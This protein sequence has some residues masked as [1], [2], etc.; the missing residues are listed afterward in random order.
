MKR[1]SL[2]IVAVLGLVAAAVW[3]PAAA[4]TA[5]GKSS[6]QAP[7]IIGAAVDLTSSMKPFD[8]PALAGAQIE[9]GKLAAK[10][11]ANFQIKVCNHQLKKQKSCA[12]QLIQQGAKIA[13]V[14]CDVEYA[15][16]ATQEFLNKG[17][18]TMSPCVTTDQMGPQR[19]GAKG[20]LA[21][22]VGGTALDEG[23]A[24]AEYAYG[25]GWR[26]AIVVKDNYLVY[27]RN[28]SDAFAKRFQELGGKI[29]DREAFT[30]FDKTIGNVISKVAPMK[31]DVISFV[32]AFGELPQFVA[33]IRSAG[34]KTPIINSWGGDGTYW[35]PKSPKVTDYY[36]DN[37]ASSFGDDPNAAVNSL[38]KSLLAAKKVPYTASFVLGAA[39]I[40]ILSQAL[41]RTGGST[42]GAKLAAAIQKFHKVPTISGP[43]TYS[44]SLHSV[45]GRPWRIMKVQNNKETF[46][47]M[48]KTRKV[49][50]LK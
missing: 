18:L 6:A 30:S 23:S 11:G 4:T 34:N 8:S 35:N 50:S 27:F 12:A 1:A 5:S 20:K 9:A 21:F 43:V 49:V 32:T 31:A 7:I 38:L 19:F 14:T 15:A 29:V 46:L 3:L 33:G 10:G 45:T 2:G 48:W 28:V 37:Y 41:K 47:R 25:R 24:E 16:A 39:T 36:V 26:T 40:D 42:N 13:L 44:P 17:I 22:T